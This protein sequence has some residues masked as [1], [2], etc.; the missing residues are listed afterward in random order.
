MEDTIVLYPSPSLGHV[1]SMVELG[2]LLLHHHGRRGNHQFPITILLTTGFW[3]IPTIISYIDS[4]S[5]AYRSLSFRRLPSISVDNSQKCSRAAIGF[6]FIRL[7]A[8]NVLHSLEEIS[9][10][11]K[12]SAFV[13]DI[14]CT[15]ALSTGKDLKIPTFYFYTSGASSLAAFLQFPKLDEQTTGSFKDQPDTVFHFHG[16]PLLKAIHMP[17]PALDRE[18]PAYHDFVVYSRLA[19]SDGIIVN[20]FEDLEPIS[21][22][23]I[24]KSFCTYILIIVVSSHEVS[25]II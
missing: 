22:K 19:K 11:Y 1:V 21:I 24:A 15:S 3:D 10:S 17:E 20:T 16:A 14:F 5:Q 23:V 6:Q 4:V 18:D 13:I 2:K 8:P 25:I 12:I 7:N 9:K